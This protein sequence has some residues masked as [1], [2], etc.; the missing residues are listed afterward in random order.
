ML[1][2]GTCAESGAV[3]KGA[4]Q[5]ALCMWDG[6][7]LGSVRGSEGRSRRPGGVFGGDVG[8]HLVSMSVLIF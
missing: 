6:P 2:D 8:S 5:Q 3:G 1:K 4:H 7:T